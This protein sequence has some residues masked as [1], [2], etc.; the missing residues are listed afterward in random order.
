MPIRQKPCLF[1]CNTD[2]QVFL[3]LYTEERGLLKSDLR[4]TKLRDEVV[5]E[6]A[7]FVYAI[8]PQL[9]QPPG[10]E[11]ALILGLLR[12]PL[13]SVERLLGGSE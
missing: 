5:S 13:F 10:A 6:Q 7:P 1:T 2:V 9:Q 8:L 12:S 11:C 4:K 3:S